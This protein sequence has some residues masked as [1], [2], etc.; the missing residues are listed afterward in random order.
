MGGSHH[1]HL[2]AVKLKA[3][4]AAINNE[5]TG[6]RWGGKTSKRLEGGIREGAKGSELLVCYH[7]RCRKKRKE[8]PTPRKNNQK[9]NDTKGKFGTRHTNV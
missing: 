2:A 7:S 9:L 6:D 1:P 5:E 8:S 3:G 4:N